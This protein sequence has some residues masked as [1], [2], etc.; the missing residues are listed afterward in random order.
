MV[1]VVCVRFIQRQRLAR[2]VNLDHVTADEVSAQYAIY[3]MTEEFFSLRHR[4]DAHLIRRE[5]G[6]GQI[7]YDAF[8]KCEVHHALPTVGSGDTALAPQL[9]TESGC[10]LLT[11]DS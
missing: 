11:D 5:A 6:V 7:D 3:R 1:G 8:G 4:R 9:Q 2:V 10:T